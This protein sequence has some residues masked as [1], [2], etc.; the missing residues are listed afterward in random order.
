MHLNTRDFFATCKKASTA[1]NHLLKK[2]I[3]SGVLQKE[4]K[5]LISIST[6]GDQMGARK[7]KTKKNLNFEIRSPNLTMS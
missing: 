3:N 2:C 5:E 1:L 7:K 4:K 6:Q